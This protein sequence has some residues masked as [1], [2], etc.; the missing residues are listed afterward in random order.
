MYKITF[1]GK[2][3][4]KLQA[5]IEP[6]IIYSY[7][8]SRGKEILSNSPQTVGHSFPPRFPFITLRTGSSLLPL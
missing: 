7:Y 5:V 8:K 1:L 3:R 4:F 6:L 2:V